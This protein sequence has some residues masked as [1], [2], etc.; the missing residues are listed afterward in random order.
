[1]QHIQRLLPVAFV[2]QIVPVGMMLFTG[3][4]LLQNGMPQSMQRAPCVLA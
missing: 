2:N 3:Q 1:M 4:P